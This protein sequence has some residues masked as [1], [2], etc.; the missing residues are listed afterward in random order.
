MGTIYLG[1]DFCHSV[2]NILYF[3]LLSENLKIEVYILIL[4]FKDRL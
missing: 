2:H 4:P 3:L 1:S